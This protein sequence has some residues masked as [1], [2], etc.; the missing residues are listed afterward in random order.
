MVLDKDVEKR[1]KAERA[2]QSLIESIILQTEE[3][4]NKLVTPRSRQREEE[5]T[6]LLGGRKISLY[7][8]EKVIAQRAQDYS[9]KFISSYYDE[10]F[11]LNGWTGPSSRRPNIVAVWT[12]DLIYAR[13]SKDVLPTLQ[14]LN[15]FIDLGIRNYKHFQWLNDRGVEMLEGFIRDAIRLMKTCNTWYEFRMKYAQEFN[16]PVQLKMFENN[17]SAI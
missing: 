2:K 8:I 6:E 5:I 14:I 13:F 10:I 1:Q 15:P 3:L 7:E 9:V 16:L 4:T 11:R 12:N 17:D